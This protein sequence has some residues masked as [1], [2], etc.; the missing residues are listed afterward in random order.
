MSSTPSKFLIDTNII[1][2]LE[3][4]KEIGSNYSEL[5]RICSEYAIQICIHES[6]YQDILQDKDQERRKIS[7]SKLEKYPRVHRTPRTTAQKEA[8]FGSIKKHNDEV[9]TDILVSLDLGAADILVTEDRH[10]KKRV[11]NTRLESRVLD[12]GEA[13][14]ELKK[15]FGAVLVDYK[16]VQDKFCNQYHHDLPFFTSLKNDYQEFQAWYEKCMAKQRPCWV[17]EQQGGIAGLIIYK[18]EDRAVDSDKKELEELNIPGSLVLKICLFKVD[19]S[20]RGEKFGE[21]LLK[22]A[23]DYAYRN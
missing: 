5:N 16:H 20:I 23:M 6:S 14:A 9:D 19:E 3:G 13:L 18:D 2:D 4:N 15:I 1:I 10:L 21:Q 17:I 7:L 22:N 12:V 8:I 11:K